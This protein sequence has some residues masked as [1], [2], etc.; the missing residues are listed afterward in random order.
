MLLKAAGVALVLGTFAWMGYLEG[1]NWI[2]EGAKFF[3]WAVLVFGGMFIF[4][5]VL[6]GY[7]AID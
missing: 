1:P 5:W 3:G 2:R 7:G 6:Q 4:I